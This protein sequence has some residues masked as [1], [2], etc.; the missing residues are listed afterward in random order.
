MTLP[1]IASGTET[2]PTAPAD[3][4]LA[5]LRRQRGNKQLAA[6]VQQQFQTARNDRSKYERQWYLNLQMYRG[7]QNVEFRRMPTSM[8]GYKLAT[9]PAPPWRVR[10]VIN[11]IRPIARKEMSKLTAQKPTFIV[12]PATMTDEDHAAARVAE[13]V[14]EGRYADLHIAQVQRQWVWW[15]VICGTSFLYD[16]WD[17]SKGPQLPGPDGTPAPAGDT[18]VEAVDPFHVF[19]PD[20][21]E[22]TIDGQ[23]WVLH[24]STRSPEYVKL[25]YGMD[26]PGSRVRATELFTDDLLLG[27]GAPKPTEQVLIL[28]MWLRPGGHKDFPAGGLITVVGDQ[29]YQAI[30]CAKTGPIFRHNELPFTKLDIMPGGSFYSDSVLV[31]LNPL[32]RIYNRQRGQ[33]IESG[34]LMGKPKWIAPK[35]SVKGASI[36]SEPGQIILYDVVGPPPTMVAPPSLPEY[37]QGQPGQALQDMDDISGQHEISRG[38]APGQVTAATAISYLQEQDDTMLAWAIASLEDGMARVGKHILAHVAQFWGVPRAVRVVGD[39]LSFDLVQFDA[40]M[41]AGNTDVRVEA[42]SALPASRSA[43]QATGLELFKL[44]AF[45]PPGTPEASKQLLELLDMSGMDKALEEWR[46]DERQALRENVKMAAGMPLQPN[47]YDNHAAHIRVHNRFRKGQ[48]FES[49]PPQIQEIFA[50]H[51]QMHE[52]MN[53]G[54]QMVAMQ[55]GMG[56]AGPTDQAGQPGPDDQG[57]PPGASG[58]PPPGPGGTLPPGPSDQGGPPGGPPPGG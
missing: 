51:V 13:Q 53:M 45:G 47:N 35:G 43:K 41:L 58:G 50:V 46:V 14:L 33:I 18:C 28:E 17:R 48:K 32:Q 12:V 34:N 52:E 36:D 29:V 10:P 56:P 16:Y 49:L 15:G 30:D 5:G 39:D 42:G 37:V 40:S 27:T 44:G 38:Q 26:V 55:A 6:W 31:D 2:G 9:P 24:A 19:V 1:S 57:G 8:A 20:L 21:R 25:Y 7:N 3:G 4:Y 11:R 22:P 23:P 54:Q